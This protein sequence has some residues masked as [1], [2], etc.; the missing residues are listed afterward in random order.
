MPGATQRR[1]AAMR[2]AEA[3]PL[4]G[5]TAVTRGGGAQPLQADGDQGRV[6]GGA[7]LHRRLVRAPARRRSSRAVSGSNSTS[8]RRCSGRKG[9]DGKPRKSSFGPWMMKAFRDARRAQGACAARRSTC[10]AIPRSGAWNAAC[11]REYEGDLDLI[12]RSLAPGRIEA[13]AALA[14]VPALIRGY[15]HV[16]RGQRGQGSRRARA[17]CRAPRPRPL[18]S[19]TLRAAE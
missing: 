12:L 17:A 5:S 11:L 8:R 18:K 2:E 4:P 10:S 6:R 13:A 9:P 15:G 16:K 19:V 7:A 3:K 1:V 14:S